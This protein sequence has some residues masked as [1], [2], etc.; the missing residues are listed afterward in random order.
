MKKLLAAVL[1][2]ALIFSVAACAAP[3]ATE[4]AAVSE[5]PAASEEAS[6]APSESASE[7]PTQ[8]AD[9]SWQTVESKGSFV[10]G[11][12]AGFAPMGFKDENG[13]YV[14]FDIDLANEVAS[15]LGLKIVFQPINWDLKEMELKNGNID[16]IWNGL[17]I[18][19]ERKENM[20][21]SD[22][23]M[24]NQQ[25]IVVAADSGIKSKADLA[26]KTVA[27]QVDSS[28][29]E[30]IE[31]EPDVMDT[32]GQLIESPD[33]VEALMELKNGSVDAVVVDEMT[34]R[35]YVLA[36]N[37]DAY[38]VLE[39]TFG[40]EQYG[41]GFRLE[42]KTFRDKIQET[43]NALIADGTAAKISQKWFGDNV[44]IGG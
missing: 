38:L 12:D 42:D 28:A 13:E 2:L 19:D 26:G 15:R 43:I 37:P 14:G 18:T 7:E 44:V 23:Y 24:N 30:A 17:T 8:E 11:F 34:G 32:F 35:Y 5:T 9:A 40:E 3:A 33:Y 29:M 39:D 36:D 31:A 16:M 4:S 27:A 10:L 1:A 25:I 21:F 22:P 6:A 41:I 20:L